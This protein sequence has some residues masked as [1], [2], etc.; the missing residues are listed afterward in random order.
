MKI[1]TLRVKN[2]MLSV[3][4]VTLSE[5][6]VTPSVKRVTLF[7]KNVTHSEKSVTLSVKNKP[8]R[9][10][11]SHFQ[12]ENHHSNKGPLSTRSWLRLQT[13]HQAFPEEGLQGNPCDAP[14]KAKVKVM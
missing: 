9:T 11:F 14:L 10:V 7:G 1:V 5:K 12:P 13:S 3:K 6:S 2:D 4:N 8:L